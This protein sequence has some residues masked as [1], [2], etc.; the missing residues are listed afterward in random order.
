MISIVL[1]YWN[2]AKAAH[3][4]LASLAKCYADL[5]VEVIVVDDGSPEAFEPEGQYPWP[6]TVLR[7]PDKTVALNP[8]VPFNE[9]VGVARGDLIVISNVETIHEKPVL[10]QM[11]ETL[12]EL[13]P[14]GYVLAAA[15]CPE[16]KE[17]HCHSSIAGNRASGERQAEGS[18]LHFCAMLNRSLWD[19]VG[20]FDARY[21]NGAGYEDAD[22]VNRL[23]LA[24]AVFR[25]RDDLVVT[26]PRNG[27]RANWPFGA[28]ARNRDLFRKTWP[29]SQSRAS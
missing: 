27:A 22:F 26:H 25:I 7:L 29:C 16:R 4:A 11:R 20:G 19:A 21:R 6:L 8:C 14:T 9:G 28:H 1:P 17:W 24:G 15:W 5:D 10:A 12:N 3:R 18:G 13:G 23:E 2:R